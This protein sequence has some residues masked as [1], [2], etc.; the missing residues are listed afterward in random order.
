LQDAR[1]HK[2]DHHLFLALEC[3]QRQNLRHFF[4]EPNACTQQEGTNA[5]N[6][7]GQETLGQI[8]YQLGKTLQK[9]GLGHIVLLNKRVQKPAPPTS[10]SETTRKKKTKPTIRGNQNTLESGQMRVVKVWRPRTVANGGPQLQVNRNEY[11]VKQPVVYQPLAG[12]AT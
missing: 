8:G 7:G 1:E 5:T 9:V 10:V 4:T 6:L 12:H 2:R 11:Q 3:Q